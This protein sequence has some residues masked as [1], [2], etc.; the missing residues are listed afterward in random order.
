MTATL[1]SVYTYIEPPAGRLGATI[2]GEAIVHLSAAIRAA[3]Q[4]KQESAADGD[5]FAPAPC[6]T[7]EETG[8]APSLIEQLI[9]KTLHF[10]GELIGRELASLLG[11]RFSLI[12]PL[13]EQLKRVRQVDV[14]TSLG[15][16]PVSAIYVLAESGRIR[17]REC[18]ENNQYFGP[19]PVTLDQ[20]RDAVHRQRQRS[21]WLTRPMLLEAYR[22]MV[23]TDAVINQI[24]PAVNCGKSFLLYGQPGNGKTY[25]AEALFRLQ[26]P[27]IYVPYVVE[28]QG[29]LVKIFDPVYHHRLE[30]EPQGISSLAT[31]PA[32]DGRWVLCKRPFITTGGELTLD[33]LNLSYY[34]TAKIYDAPFQVKANNGIYLV[35]DFGRQ[36]C[37]PAEILN[38]WIVP[39]DRRVDFLSFVTG[40]KIE[41]PFETFLIFSTNLRPDQLGDEAFLR[42][43]EYKL[44][45]RSP[46]EAEFLEIFRRYAESRGFAFDERLV[47][48]FVA[49]RY[50]AEKRPLRRCHPRDLITHA[51]DLLQFEGRPMELT[52]EALNQAYDSCFLAN[53]GAD[54]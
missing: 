27:P 12:E 43:I 26:S 53:E 47:R 28:Y 7:L 24:G 15:Y 4:P 6:R 16:G 17:A 52:A 14:K 29:Q 32:H 5:R 18:L 49:R 50:Y 31:E 25:L 20:Y 51:I 39:M 8:I 33:M 3:D 38:R 54:V 19:A 10:R 41:M 44:L 48:Q 2:L 45:M 40:G 23:I 9:L 22:H 1:A 36:Q 37:S 11:L 34:P 35:D 46:E 30:P 13:L 21:G 42:R